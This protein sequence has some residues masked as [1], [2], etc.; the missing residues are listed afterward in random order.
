MGKSTGFLEF[1][2]Q[3]FPERAPLERI[4]DWNEFHLHV[5][6]KDLQQQGALCMDCGIPFAIRARCRMAV[7]PSTISFRSGTT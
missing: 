1:E 7:A 5:S 4:Q 6:I 2:R 3:S